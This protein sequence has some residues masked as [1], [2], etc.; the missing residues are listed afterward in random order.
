MKPNENEHEI[1]TTLNTN[2]ISFNV[3]SISF[4]FRFY[5]HE[6]HKDTYDNDDAK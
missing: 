2:I 1:Q 4:P 3:I 5:Y 6:E